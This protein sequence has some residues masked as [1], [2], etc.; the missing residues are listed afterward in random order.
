MNGL[1]KQEP[2]ILLLGDVFIFIG[3]L[4]VALFLRYGR[5]PDLGLLKGHLYAFIPLII[6]WLVIFFIAGLYERHTMLLRSRLPNIVIGAQIANGIVAVAF[7]YFASYLTISPKTI[8]FLYVVLS[9]VGAIAWRLYGYPVIGSRNKQ[10]AF[11]IGEGEEI[12]EL[13]AEVNHN[14]LYPMRFVSS[15]DVDKLSGLDL[16]KDLIERVY[17]DEVTVI[18]VDTMNDHIRPILPHVYNLVFS[19]ITFISLHKLYEEIFRRVPLT[20]VRYNWFL[21]NISASSRTTYDIA[22]RIMDIIISIPLLIVPLVLTPFIWLAMKIEDGGPVFITQN[23]VGQY[24]KIVRFVK[25]RTMSFSENG[26]WKGKGRENKVTKIGAFLRRTRLDEFPQLWNV[27]VGDAS[28]IGPRPEFPEPVKHYM[29]ELPYYNI[30][31]IIKP[32][33]SGWAQLYGEHPHHGI[34]VSQTANKLSYDLYYLKNRSFILDIKIALR[35][36][37]VLFSRSGV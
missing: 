13:E 24:N 32:G 11:L 19:N 7:F 3:A 28:L 8:L 27:L 18:A 33:L 30:R 36:V 15:I 16:K 10:N 4:W 6:I 12:R 14:N 17:S 37:Q 26:D 35:T 23:R 34:S 25:F 2:L 22:K 5:T 31:H 1:N 9:A 21:E 20:L 29:E